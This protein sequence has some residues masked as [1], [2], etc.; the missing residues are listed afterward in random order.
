[1][2]EDLAKQTPSLLLDPKHPIVPIE[3]E[4]IETK[5]TSTFHKMKDK[6]KKSFKRK[7][8]L[9]DNTS[10]DDGDDEQVATNS[11]VASRTSANNEFQNSSQ[12]LDKV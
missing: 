1:M 8:K 10:T 12:S 9:A 3:N 5:S 11:D 7:N 4:Q 2:M 6:I